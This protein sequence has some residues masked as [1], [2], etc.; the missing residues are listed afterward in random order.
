MTYM[1]TT[2]SKIAFVAVLLIVTNTITA[3]VVYNG[4][5]SPEMPII[6]EPEIPPTDDPGTP[7]PEPIPE[8]VY[9]KTQVTL[10]VDPQNFT[11]VPTEFEQS[12][13]TYD[14]YRKS[15]RMGSNEHLSNVGVNVNC[16]W[17]TSSE[18]FP[19]AFESSKCKVKFSALNVVLAEVTYG[20]QYG[21]F[22]LY[23]KVT[24][25]GGL[26][27]SAGDGPFTGLFL[28]PFPAHVTLFIREQHQSY[29]HF[30]FWGGWYVTAENHQACH[31]WLEKVWQILDDPTQFHYQCHPIEV[32]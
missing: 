16:N 5:S 2:A 3:A 32:S 27:D 6:D 21:G 9:I 1:P 19:R 31:D 18:A 23:S 12:R 22:R 11:I 20:A 4:V 10:W 24:L 15:F 7:L 28:P 8:Y 30:A 17:Y 25:G 13:I 26:Q 14:G 29:D